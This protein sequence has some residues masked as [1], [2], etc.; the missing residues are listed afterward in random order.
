MR[1][2]AL[3][4]LGIAD[5]ERIAAFLDY[6]VHTINTY[7]TRIKNKSIVENDEFESRIMAI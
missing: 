6:S 7:K 1:I 5:S 3:I 4:R 2:Y